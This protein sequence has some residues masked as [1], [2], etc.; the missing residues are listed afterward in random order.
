[1][2]L[3]MS[4][5]NLL[6]IKQWTESA[7]TLQIVWSRSLFKVS[8]LK[9]LEH[10]SM[11]TYIRCK[12]CSVYHKYERYDVISYHCLI[13]CLA[14]SIIQRNNNIS[15]LSCF[16]RRYINDKRSKIMSQTTPRLPCTLANPLQQCG[17]CA[18]GHLVFVGEHRGLW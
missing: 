10:S 12:W 4:K 5:N 8:F 11:N 15:L 13:N 2:L 1:M 17:F 7:G 18:D 14:L 16:C 3:M 9:C 6:I